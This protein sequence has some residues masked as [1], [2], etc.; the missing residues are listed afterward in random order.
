VDVE[1][2][3]ISIPC[4]ACELAGLRAKLGDW[5]DAG[6]VPATAAFPVKLVV[7]EAAKNAIAHN[8]SEDSVL[9]RAWLDEDDV[10]VEIVD[11]NGA[12]WELDTERGAEIRGLTLIH[13][14]ARHVETVRMDGGTAVVMLLA[15]R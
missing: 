7:H 3:A 14:L 9:V 12:A 11:K 2:F 4:D 5:L 13:G 1:Q 10:V 15:A 8:A 6:R